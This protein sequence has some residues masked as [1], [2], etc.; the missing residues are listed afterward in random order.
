MRDSAQLRLLAGDLKA[1]REDLDRIL[2]EA[3]QSLEDLSSREPTYLEVRGAGDIL[4]DLYNVVEH[5]FE[6]VAVEL[7]G[8]LPAGPDSHAQL[9]R[10]MSRDA[11]GI[12]PAVIDEPMRSRLHE[13]LRKT[14][15]KVPQV[16]DTRRVCSRSAYPDYRRPDTRCRTPAR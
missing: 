13:Y 16:W 7:D 3:A 12:R 15:E 9:I 8:A 5:F 1:D 14:D 10:R 2:G 11:E 4:H 6:R